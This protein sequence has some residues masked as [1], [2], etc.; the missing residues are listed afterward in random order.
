MARITFRAGMFAQQRPVALFCV[1][2]IAL[3]PVFGVMTRFAFL[4]IPSFVRVLFFMASHT[5]AR[6]VL[7][8][9]ID[10]T[11][12][13]GRRNMLAGKRESRLVMIK[14][15]VFPVFFRMAVTAGYAQ[16]SFVDI[17]FFVTIVTAAGRIA[18]FRIQFVAGLAISLYVRAVKRVIGELM[19]ER[20]MIKCSNFHRAAFVIGV[21]GFTLLSRDVGCF[22]VEAF[23][24]FYICGD[25]LV[26]IQ[27]KRGLFSLLKRQMTTFAF[28]FC[29]G[30]TFN[31]FTGHHQRIEHL[32]R[33]NRADDEPDRH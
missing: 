6:R 15:C 21:A 1:A 31:H 13:A 30:V 20:C 10:M 22:T 11:T 28:P 29:L 18:K 19:F 2:E 27:A 12:F 23:F 3:L 24:C 16:A 33:R 25:I 5:R 4:T 32:R 8:F 9:R 17:V 26:A 7:V 14:F